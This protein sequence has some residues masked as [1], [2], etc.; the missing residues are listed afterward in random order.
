[1]TKL[2]RLIAKAEREASRARIEAA[3]KE[4]GAAVAAN[5]CP[6]CGRTLRYNSSIQG[7]WQCSQFGRFGSCD[8][9]GFTES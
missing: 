6:K 3:Q 9:Q 5:K 1:M 8:W 2:E 4:V 7:W